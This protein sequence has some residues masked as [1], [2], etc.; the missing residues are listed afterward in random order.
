MFDTSHM[1]QFVLRGPA[2][3]GQLGRIGTQD[4]EALSVG[5]CQY[6]FLLNEDAGVIDDT[7]LMRLGDEEFLLVV[8]AGPGAGDLEWLRSHMR[9]NVELADQ[10][11]GGWG[12]VDL[13]GPASARALLSL[14]DVDLA[15]MAYFSVARARCCGRDCIISRTGYTGELRLP[16]LGLGAP[17]DRE[18]WEPVPKGGSESR[19]LRR[20]GPWKMA[21]QEIRILAV[22]QN[23]DLQ[24]RYHHSSPTK[25]GGWFHKGAEHYP[26]YVL[27]AE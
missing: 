26:C 15:G 14:V 10:S 6:G 27:R 16:W 19:P 18:T 17:L 20:R 21:G 3:A 2:A 4:A 7:I 22:V 23:G 9:G 11:T 8:N 13:Q 12:K 25:P 1:R 24:E 5:R